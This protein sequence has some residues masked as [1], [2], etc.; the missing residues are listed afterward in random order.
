MPSGERSSTIGP[1]ILGA[2]III[3]SDGAKPMGELAQ[4]FSG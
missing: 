3:I 2:Q 1:F 4:R